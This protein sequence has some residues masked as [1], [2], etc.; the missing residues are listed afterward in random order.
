M[1]RSVNQCANPEPAIPTHSTF[2][3]FI[4][5]RQIDSIGE[6]AAFLY[7]FTTPVGL[8]VLVAFWALVVGLLKQYLQA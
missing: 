5:T 4:P 8:M 2:L 1:H 6:P 3:Y 7:L